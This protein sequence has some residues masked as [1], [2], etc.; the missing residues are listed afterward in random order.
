MCNTAEQVSP[1]SD[2]L[3]FLPFLAGER[4]PHWG[5]NVRGTLFGLSLHHGQ[6]HVIRALLE[7]V[8][9]QIHSVVQPLEDLVGTS[10]EVRATGGF[11]RSPVWLQ[12]LSDVM[13]RELLVAKESEG[14]VLGAAAL[15]LRTLGA[16]D[17]FQCLRDKNP[18]RQSIRPRD[19]VHRFYEQAFQ[20]Y[21]QLYWK[22]RPEFESKGVSRS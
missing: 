15:A 4:S 16:I 6:P 3:F 21:L 17:S 9:Y 11:S 12:I 19:R 22:L 14:S 8:C 1:G 13:G 10:R 20:R 2:G 5:S 18:V 7:G